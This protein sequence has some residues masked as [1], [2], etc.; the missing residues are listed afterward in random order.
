MQRL[1][2]D[3]QCQLLLL[4]LDDIVTYSSS[5]SQHLE[6]LFLGRLQQEGLKAKL[7]KCSFF[8]SRVK[9]L[10][11]VISQESVSKD[12]SKIEAATEWKRPQNVVEL[13]SFLG[14]AS[15]YRRFVEGC[16]KLAAP[17]NKW[18]VDIAGSKH[19]KASGK[20][21][22]E[23]WTPQCKESFEAL[24]AKLVSYADF[25]KPF[26]L[27]TDISYNGRGAVLSQETKGSSDLLLMPVVV[28]SPLSV[29]WQTTIPCNW[30]FLHSNGP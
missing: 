14:F 19:K 24:K 15:Y 26:F 10:G 4:Y 25:S 7:E 2:G 16:A 17:L 11:H 27:E 3:Q 20:P 29:I 22:D 9:Y 18:V 5:V 1:F 13:C 23:V 6:R 28:F 12:P 8:Q 30:N 21:L